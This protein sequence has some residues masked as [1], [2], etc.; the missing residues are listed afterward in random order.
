MVDGNDNATATNFKLFSKL[1]GHTEL[2]RERH[3]GMIHA[4]SDIFA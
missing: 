3:N 1:E 4:T 2:C